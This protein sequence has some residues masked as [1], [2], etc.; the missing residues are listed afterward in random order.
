MLVNDAN[1]SWAGRRSPL[2]LGLLLTPGACAGAERD[3]PE[4]AG[5]RGEERS[6]PVA[7]ASDHASPAHGSAVSGQRLPPREPPLL[8]PAREGVGSASREPPPVRSFALGAMGAVLMTTLGDG[9]VYALVDDDGDHRVDRVYAVTP[10]LDDS[11]EL[12]GAAKPVFVSVEFPIRQE[13]GWRY[14][15][16]GADGWLYVPLVV[17]DRV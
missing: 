10:S 13:H 5:I 8:A 3:T 16:F 12:D 4:A 17:A 2:L 15:R 11:V 7:P 9:K 14:L 1:R 6:A